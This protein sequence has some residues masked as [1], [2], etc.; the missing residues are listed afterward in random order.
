MHRPLGR[1]CALANV[2]VA[3]L[4]TSLGLIQGADDA[5]TSKTLP[6]AAKVEVDFA[7][8][9]KPLFAKY[10]FKCHGPEKQQSGLRLDVQ[11]D[12]VRGGDTG[13][14]FEVGKSAES[15]LIKY[16][17]GLD[18]ELVMPPEGDK[19]SQNDVALFRDWSDKGASWQ[20]DDDAVTS[21]R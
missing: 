20:H 4:I 7:K 16:V 10:C 3:G 8:D 1:I 17:A 18:P 9:V 11:G 21:G 6:P 14:A 13:P 12:A 2:I 5:A 19:L 15:L